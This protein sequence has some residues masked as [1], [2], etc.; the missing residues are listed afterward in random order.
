[1]TSD[2][3]FCTT[4]QLAWCGFLN[5]KNTQERYDNRYVQ[6]KKR[7]TK[8][9]QAAPRNY[10]RYALNRRVSLTWNLATAKVIV[11]L[12]LFFFLKFRLI[13]STNKYI[14]IVNIFQDL[15][16]DEKLCNEK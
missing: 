1:M 8:A 5:V 11:H 12:F 13:Q 10:I 7:K 3:P 4:A 2:K 6:P 15:N 9:L 16:E 14:I